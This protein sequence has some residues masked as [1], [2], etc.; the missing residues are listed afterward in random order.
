MPNYSKARG[1]FLRRKDNDTIF[2]Y[3][4]TCNSLSKRARKHHYDSYFRS[5]L[6]VHQYIRNIGLDAFY[7]QLHKFHP[8]SSSTELHQFESLQIQKLIKKHITLCNIHLLKTPRPQPTT[9]CS[10]GSVIQKYHLKKH[11][12]SPIHFRNLPFPKSSLSQIIN[13][14]HIPITKPTKKSNKK[15]KSKTSNPKPKPKKLYTL[16]DCGIKYLNSSLK[17]HIL[18]S[19]HQEYFRP[20]THYSYSPHL[21]SQILQAPRPTYLNKPSFVS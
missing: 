7:I 8:C 3:G 1:Y 19:E 9:R 21:F 14:Q 11:L 10:C 13:L 12:A 6:P 4:T 20:H 17:Y 18:S 16:C 15:S 5:K 2:Y